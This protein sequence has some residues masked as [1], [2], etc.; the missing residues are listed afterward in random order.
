M[1]VGTYN[2]IVKIS[3]NDPDEPIVDVIAEL[4]IIE[5]TSSINDLVQFNFKYHPNPFE[6]SINLSANEKFTSV[7]IYSLLGQ[8]LMEINP[9]NQSQ[10]TIDMS[11]LSIGTYFMKVVINDKSSSMKI[12]KK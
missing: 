10:L 6:N 8:E 7:K 1:T 4:I 9:D 12:I 2:G 5:D 3:S 11:D